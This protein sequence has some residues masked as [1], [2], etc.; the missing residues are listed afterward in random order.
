MKTIP[1]HVLLILITSV[2]GCDK[3]TVKRE[4][5]ELISLP[6]PAVNTSMTMSDASLNQLLQN[7]VSQQAVQWTTPN[8]WTELQGSGMR[9]VTFHSTNAD[10]IE[11]SIVSLG[12]LAG[13]LEANLVRWLNQIGVT[14]V[15]GEQLRSFIANSPTLTTVDNQT[16]QIFDL[17]E[18]QIPAA[19]N[20]SMMVAIIDTGAET[21]FLKMT[22]TQAAIYDQSGQFKRLIQSIQLNH[23]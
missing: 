6:A 4:Y 11:C 15:P 20:P 16:A 2:T 19:N 7:S 9:M 14:N 21:I 23:E 18:L 10:P 5:Q 17:M 13:G 22:G 12:G 1:I 3:K 8:G